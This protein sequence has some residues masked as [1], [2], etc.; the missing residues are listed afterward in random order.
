[1]PRFLGII[2][3]LGTL[4]FI[5]TTLVPEG[6]SSVRSWRD[7]YYSVRVRFFGALVVAGVL[8]AVNTTVLI[9]S[10]STILGG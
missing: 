10:R 1:M 3:Q 6:A 5:V 9:G 7:H 4:Y 2:A 8:T